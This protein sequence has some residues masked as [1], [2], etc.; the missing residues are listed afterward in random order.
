M[1]VRKVIVLKC[2]GCGTTALPPRILLID[3]MNLETPAPSS[4]TEARHAAAVKGWRHTASG[5]DLCP[6]CQTEKRRPAKTGG[7][8]SHI[9]HPHWGGH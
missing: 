5:K 6:A 8:L 9:P 4:V 7:L 3:L 1:T 2:E